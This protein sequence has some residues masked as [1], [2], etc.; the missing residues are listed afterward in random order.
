MNVFSSDSAHE[1]LLTLVI[2][3]WELG[4]HTTFSIPTSPH[5]KLDKLFKRACWFKECLFGYIGWDQSYVAIDFVNYSIKNTLDP[6]PV[7]CLK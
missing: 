6:S 5:D 7:D 1:I 4:S 2:S 3:F